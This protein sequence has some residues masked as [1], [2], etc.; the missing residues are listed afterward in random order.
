MTGDPNLPADFDLSTSVISVDWPSL[1]LPPSA[2]V[3]SQDYTSAMEKV[4]QDI[5]RAKKITNRMAF[6]QKLGL[7]KEEFGKFTQQVS[8]VVN[9]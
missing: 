5:L 3:R 2:L 1:D 8:S 4:E 9:H 6:Y 7:S